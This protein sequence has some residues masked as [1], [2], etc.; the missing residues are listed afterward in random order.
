MGK[1]QGVE[2]NI[3]ACEARTLIICHVCRAEGWPIYTTSSRLAIIIKFSKRLPDQIPNYFGLILAPEPHS[4]SGGGVFFLGDLGFLIFFPFHQLLHN[5]RCEPVQ[6]P[7]LGAS[8][9]FHH[10]AGLH[11]EL[12]KAAPLWSISQESQWQAFYS[13]FSLFIC[14]A[15]GA[16][17]DPGAV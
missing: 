10:S 3:H 17:L 7:T 15:P 8:L 2:H 13:S 9:P 1:I 11:W 4:R 5:P 6:L 16:S 12:G 14:C